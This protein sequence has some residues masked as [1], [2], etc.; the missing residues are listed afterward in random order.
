MTGDKQV[1]VEDIEVVNGHVYLPDTPGLGLTLDRD[2][3]EMLKARPAVV[4]APYLIRT[5]L[6]S[7]L[8]MYNL[9]KGEGDGIFMVRPA[10]SGESH[11]G[12]PG[13]MNLRYDGAIV[14][15]ECE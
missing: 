4:C 12:R 6:K 14:G 7:G 8:V 13:V 15:T 2:K 9:M 11:F 3:L 5:S 10:V 1:V